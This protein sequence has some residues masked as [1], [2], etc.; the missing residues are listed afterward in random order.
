MMAALGQY[1]VLSCLVGSAAIAC[2]YPVAMLFG[3][4]SPR[5]FARGIVGA[6]AIAA[7]TTSSMATLPA[8]IEAAEEGLGIDPAIA[9]AV[10]PLAVSTFRY[11]N[12]ACGAA[13]L[14][15]AAH[16]AGLHPSLGTIVTVAAVLLISNVGG[17]GLPAAAILYA[18]QAPAFQ[19]LGAPLEFIPLF[20]AVYA[21]PDIFDTIANVTGDLTV[22]TVIARLARPVAAEERVL[23]AA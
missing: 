11:G 23:V 19:A 14:T 10:L 3:G 18:I 4:M 8:M 21:L 22:T 9:G 6:Q 2:C 20:I 17:V 7:G 12:L 15:F 13:T 1:V 5:R 16:L